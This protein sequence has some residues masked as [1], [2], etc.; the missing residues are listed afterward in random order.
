MDAPRALVSRPLVKG[1]KALGTRLFNSRKTKQQQW[2]ID[3]QLPLFAE[4]H[5]W[6]YANIFFTL[7]IIYKTQM[8]PLSRMKLI[9]RW[10]QTNVTST[11]VYNF[12]CQSK[13]LFWRNYNPEHVVF[14]CATST[15]CSEC[16][17]KLIAKKIYLSWSNEIR[18]TFAVCNVIV[19]VRNNAQVHEYWCFFPNVSANRSIRD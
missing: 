3:A 14:I 12:S 7:C 5:F 11:C 1:N 10:R 16:R 4:T 15:G 19:F 6:V 17:Q 2:T 9:T 8:A 13:R 18:Q